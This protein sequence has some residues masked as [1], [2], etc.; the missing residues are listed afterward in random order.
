MVGFWGKEELSER[1]IKINNFDWEN[2][3]SQL[4]ITR[5]FLSGTKWKDRTRAECFSL[6]GMKNHRGG[7]NFSTLIKWMKIHYTHITEFSTVNTG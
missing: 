3:W 6:K 7:M 1:E 4:C 5:R 2:I